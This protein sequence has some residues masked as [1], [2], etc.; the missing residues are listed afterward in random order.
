LGK[1]PAVSLKEA[2]E[3]AFKARKILGDGVDPGAKKDAT[4]SAVP[5]FQSMAREWWNKF[6][7]PNQGGYPA[8]VW[9][10]LERDVF[11]F[12]GERQIDTITAPDVLAILRRIEERGT[13]TA[14]HKVKSYISQTFKYAIACGHALINPARDLAGALAPVKSKPMAAI[15]E[16]KAVGALMRAIDGYTGSGV[17][18]CALKLSALTFLRPGELRC[19]LWTGIDF[20]AAEWRLSADEMKMKRPHIVPLS[21]QSLE[22]FRVLYK[23]SGQGKYMF[24][25]IRTLARP[26]SDMTV[27]AALRALGYPG[28]VMTPH[29]FR[30]MATSLLSERGWSAEVIERQLAHVEGNKVR[31]AYHRS[32][33]LEER[34]RMMQEWADY[35]DELKN[36]S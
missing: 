15:T 1:Y 11:P 19:G 32:E 9:G 4:E 2:R 12:I 34:R 20:D 5:A 31:A 36:L 16:P 8:E 25:S 3:K 33:H 28:N 6:M 10:R 18:H 14:A 7:A 24:P 35:L 27:G 30:A 13:I 26:L 22:V 21:R 17:V 29:G 23:F